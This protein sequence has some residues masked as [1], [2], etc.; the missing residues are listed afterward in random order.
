[1]KC[2]HVAAKQYAPAVEELKARYLPE[3][4]VFRVQVRES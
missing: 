2:E 3:M 1:M 4:W